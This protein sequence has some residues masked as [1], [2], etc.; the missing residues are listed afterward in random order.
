MS[1][2][3]PTLGQRMDRLETLLEKLIDTD[4]K[5]HQEVSTNKPKPKEKSK[6]KYAIKSK[7]V[8]QSVLIPRKWGKEKA[9]KWIEEHDYKSTKVDKT[10]NFYRFRQSPATSGVEYYTIKLPSGI[11]LINKDMLIKKGK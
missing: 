1:S 4:E 11:E 5:F 8:V 9:V 7:S 10:E 3:Y 6:E 2:R